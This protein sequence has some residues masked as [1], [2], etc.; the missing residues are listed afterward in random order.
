M[1]MKEVQILELRKNKH[2]Y[3]KCEPIEYGKDYFNRFAVLGDS[4]LGRDINAARLSLA[5]QYGEN[6]P[7]LDIGIGDG[8]FI[9]KLGNCKGFDVNPYGINWLR[10][11]G[12]FFNPYTDDMTT[13]NLLTF[14]DALEHIIDPCAILSRVKYGSRVIVSIPIFTDINHVVSSKHF[15]PGEHYHYFTHQGLIEYM[16]TMGYTLLEH[17][18]I[19]TS[20]GREG[21]VTFVF[22]KGS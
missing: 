4:D 13:V 3:A 5:L 19:E 15:K 16:G 12:L 1:N 17:N 20:L 10:R 6:D 9:T 22:K 18:D 7:A 21:I 8:T 2:W 11:R 14:F